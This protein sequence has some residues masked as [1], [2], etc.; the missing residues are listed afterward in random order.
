MIEFNTEY[1]ELTTT[2][3]TVLR[4]ILDGLKNREIA[5]YL[6][7]SQRTAEVHRLAIMKKTGAANLASLFF[8]AAKN[9]YIRGYKLIKID[10]VKKVYV[11]QDNFSQ[12]EFLSDE[13]KDSSSG[14]EKTI[15]IPSFHANADY[16]CK[17]N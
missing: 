13:K 2:Q 14:V 9:D 1:V 5:E 11:T 7:S 4:L 6:G 16:V 17:V 3:K 8:W 10:S 15:R 12:C